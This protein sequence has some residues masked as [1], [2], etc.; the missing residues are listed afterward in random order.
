M[1]RI[2]QVAR[3]RPEQREEYLALHRD[4]WP[5]VEA[6]LRAAQIRNYSIFL[7]EDMLFA[8]YEYHGADFAADLATI[9]ADPE[10]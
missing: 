8:Y 2:A 10:T 3:L 7:H 4:V 6:A 1:Q 9:K 5:D